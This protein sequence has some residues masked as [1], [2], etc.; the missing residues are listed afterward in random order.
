MKYAEIKAKPL[1][2]K[3]LSMTQN[4][5]HNDRL[6]KWGINPISDAKAKIT[7]ELEINKMQNKF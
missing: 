6:K 1:V 3:K 2:L 5:E 4:R 7:K